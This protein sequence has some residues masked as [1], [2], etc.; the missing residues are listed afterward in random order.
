MDRQCSGQQ[1]AIFLLIH[2]LSVEKIPE[3]VKNLPAKGSGGC[4]GI[5]EKPKVSGLMSQT[6]LISMKS[7]QV[8][9]LERIERKIKTNIN[10]DTF[11]KIVQQCGAMCAVLIYK[12][13]KYGGL[14]PPLCC[15]ALSIYL[16][17]QSS[18]YLSI[19]LSKYC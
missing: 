9:L 13:K 6:T 18:T 12:T 17:I 1:F 3:I 4:L 19:Y 7:R 8:S 10:E 11:H 2:R 14:S 15:S 5:Y 16:Y